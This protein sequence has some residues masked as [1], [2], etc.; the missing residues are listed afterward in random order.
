MRPNPRRRP[1]RDE[2]LAPQIQA[3][4]ARDVNESPSV[5]V[6]ETRSDASNPGPSTSQAPITVPLLT[7]QSIQAPPL[8][9]PADLSQDRNREA[10]LRATEKEYLTQ[11]QRWRTE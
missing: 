1:A 6:S 11:L 5:R 8:P 7:M 2:A 3:K 9:D 4:L 10:L